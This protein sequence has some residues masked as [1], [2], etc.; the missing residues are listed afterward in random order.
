[1]CVCEVTKLSVIS[2]FTFINIFIFQK[3]CILVDIPAQSSTDVFFLFL[4]RE[5]W[6]SSHGY[7]RPEWLSSYRIYQIKPIDF[8]NSIRFSNNLPLLY[9]VR[10][11]ETHRS[12]RGSSLYSNGTS[13]DDW[14]QSLYATS[15]SYIPIHGIGGTGSRI[16]QINPMESR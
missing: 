4:L 13:V 16:F 9:F 7:S 8:N 5:M 2:F 6:V 1:M 3:V 10:C 15:R 14:W 12:R 11:W